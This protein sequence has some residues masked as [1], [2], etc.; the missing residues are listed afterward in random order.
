M[1]PKGM[2][3]WSYNTVISLA[4]L[5]KN[6]TWKLSIK[7]M[8]E[9]M[10]TVKSYLL[11]LKKTEVQHFGFVVFLERNIFSSEEPL[12]KQR[13]MNSTHDLCPL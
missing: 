6:K 10:Y 4:F 3:Y 12:L 11:H 5:K 13:D 1:R 2:K 9:L 7:L 8:I